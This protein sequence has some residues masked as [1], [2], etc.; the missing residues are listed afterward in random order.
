MIVGVLALV[1]C[2]LVLGWILALGSLVPKITE[3]PTRRL[4]ND[5]A[6]GLV[7]AFRPAC[8]VALVTYAVASRAE[9]G[10]GPEFLVVPFPI[11][12]SGI[13]ALFV[14][15]GITVVIVFRTRNRPDRTDVPS[16][17][18][19]SDA[20]SETAGLPASSPEEPL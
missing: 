12:L 14:T 3:G 19:D 6:L 15:G 8:L 4:S 18:P 9:L 20:W 7:F 11:A 2:V 13:A 5:V 16:G 1:F 17:E 10:D